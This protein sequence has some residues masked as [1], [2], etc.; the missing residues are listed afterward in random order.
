MRSALALLAFV[1]FACAAPPAVGQLAINWYTI[2]GGGLTF[3]SSGS[4]TLGGTIGQ[5][6]AGTLAAGSFVLQGGFWPGAAVAGDVLGD[7]NCD[8]VFNLLDVNPF[9]LAI[10]DPAAYAAQFPGCNRDNGDIDGD[11]N[12]NVLDINPFVDLLIGG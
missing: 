3:S 8:G 6:D 12:V 7:M 11:G 2:D 4:Y 1:A 9:V 5:P 10:L